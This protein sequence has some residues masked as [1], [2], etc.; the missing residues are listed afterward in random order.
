MVEAG[1]EEPNEVGIRQELIENFST[2]VELNDF[3]DGRVKK[4][5]GY[6]I[7][8][9]TEEDSS[10]FGTDFN[11]PD[12]SNHKA[13]NSRKKHL[14]NINYCSPYLFIHL[15]HLT[16]PIV[17][18]NYQSEAIDTIIQD[19][20]QFRESLKIAD[21][22]YKWSYLLNGMIG[23]LVDKQPIQAGQSLAT[24]SNIRS[25]QVLFEAPQI[26]NFSYYNEGVNKGKLKSVAL[27]IGFKR[28]SEGNKEKLFEKVMLLELPQVG[29]YTWKYL[30]SKEEYNINDFKKNDELKFELDTERVNPQ[31]IGGFSEIPFVL[32]GEGVKDSM[33]SEVAPLNRTLLNK[34]SI[35]GSVL[36][37]QGFQRNFGVGIKPTEIKQVGEYLLT[38]IE[39]PDAN[40]ISLNAGDASGLSEE[41][42]D[43]QN[44][45]D[46]RG[47]L[48]F[49]QLSDDTRQV[50]A[51]ESKQADK[52]GKK[53]IYDLI[54]DEFEGFYKNIFRFHFLFDDPSAYKDKEFSVVIGRDFEL[55]DPSAELNESQVTFYMAKELKA[56]KAMK[57]ILKYRLS[58][59]KILPS[60]D[61]NIED[62]YKEIFTE[63][64][65]TDLNATVQLPDIFGNVNATV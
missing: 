3:T 32:L 29:N 5:E 6:L 58:R 63:I 64:D 44:Q 59:I 52:V 42:R 22:D 13:L 65:S 20:T 50:Q 10:N 15:G 9:M 35:K 60:K 23:V 62:T 51:A 53:K 26:R 41:I 39:N 48:E 55:D 31:G 27:T 54:I 17:L 30:V 7:P 24:S 16:Q 47:R 33:L 57:A 11:K 38:C 14:Y 12:L 49:N 8:Y 61:M 56:Y 21:I 28:Q 46:R 36:Y 37:N 18:K 1:K 45:L 19:V 2:Y 43:I 4:V 34:R 25:Y 40:I